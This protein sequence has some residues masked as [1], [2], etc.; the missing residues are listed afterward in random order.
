[1]D[2]E[3]IRPVRGQPGDDVD[4]ERRPQARAS[5]QPIS[6]NMIFLPER[7]GKAG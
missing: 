7:S 2:E 5:Y 6:P 3:Q 4:A 1:M